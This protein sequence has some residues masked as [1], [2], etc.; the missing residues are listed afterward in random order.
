MDNRYM[1]KL[2][3]G[4]KPTKKDIKEMVSLIQK[5][6]GRTHE[7]QCKV[8]KHESYIRK[9][10]TQYRWHVEYHKRVREEM[11][12]LMK[13][14]PWSCSWH[15]GSEYQVLF[16]KIL[17]RDR[18]ISEIYHTALTE[19]D[20]FKKIQKIRKMI[21]SGEKFKPGNPKKSWGRLLAEKLGISKKTVLESVEEKWNQL[22]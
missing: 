22:K 8:D 6:R 3:E 11:G 10:F 13:H 5:L 4:K 2:L 1:Q 19:P 17:Y 16:E 9:T 20:N 18:L 15:N 7:I 21:E 12:I 14:M